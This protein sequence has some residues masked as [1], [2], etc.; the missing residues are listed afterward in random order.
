VI[1]CCE[2]RLFVRLWDCFCFGTAI[3]RASLAAVYSKLIS[4]SLFQRGSGPLS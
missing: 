3:G 2:R 4:E 1:L